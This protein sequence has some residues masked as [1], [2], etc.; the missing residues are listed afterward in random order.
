MTGISEQIIVLYVL[1]LIM[2]IIGMEEKRTPQTFIYLG[3]AFFINMMGYYQSYSDTDFVQ[4]AYLALVLSILS[5]I[6]LI[7][8]AIE[9]LKLK[10]NDDYKNSEYKEE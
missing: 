1:G 6:F 8:H 7:Y 10:T 5:I 4:T 3:L 2:F 9:L